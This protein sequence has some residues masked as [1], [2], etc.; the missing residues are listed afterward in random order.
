MITRLLEEAKEDADKEGFCDTEIGK[1]KVTRNKLS[2][3]INALDAAVEEG[4]STILELTQ[5]VATLSEEVA[6]LDKALA[7]AGDIRA[8]EKAKNAATIKDA[9]AGAR[10]TEA[11]VNVL[12]T[13]YEKAAQ[14]TGFVQ[15]AAQSPNVKMGTDE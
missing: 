3:D 8:D 10:A 9:K 4:K 5:R 14:A 13:F 12:K 15:V 2:E 1:S 11:A 6:E 7:E